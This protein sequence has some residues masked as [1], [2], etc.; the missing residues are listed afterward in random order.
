MKKNKG[1][2][3]AKNIKNIDYLLNSE[4]PLSNMVIMDFVYPKLMEY[5][6]KKD[7]LGYTILFLK[8]VILTQRTPLSY[9]EAVALVAGN[10]MFYHKRFEH[11][12]RKIQKRLE[13]YTDDID[14]RARHTAIT[15]EIQ[16]KVRA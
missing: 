10:T 9:T 16:D 1:Q 4:I 6:K 3:I 11:Y 12:N 15:K 13:K 7:K 2:Y 8:M 14:E 5:V